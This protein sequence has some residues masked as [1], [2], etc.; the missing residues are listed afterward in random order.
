MNHTARE[1]CKTCPYRKDVARGVWHKS[2]FVKLL[3]SDANPFGGA[4]F[5]CHQDI[6]KERADQGF[7]IG[8]LLDQR[9][10]NVPSIQLRIALARNTDACAQMSEAHPP[11]GV[12]L[13]TSIAQMCRANGVRVRTFTR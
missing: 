8:W 6:R 13:Y 1:P 12:K 10:R 7:C 4:T 11:E 5:L 9:E 3:E 2:E